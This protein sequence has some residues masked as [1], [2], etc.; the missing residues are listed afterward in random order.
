MSSKLEPERH[1]LLCHLARRYLMRR[2][3]YLLISDTNAHFEPKTT[4]LITCSFYVI[5]NWGFFTFLEC[6]LSVD[7]VNDIP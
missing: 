3:F 1:P 2:N 6:F 4:M 7:S 5:F